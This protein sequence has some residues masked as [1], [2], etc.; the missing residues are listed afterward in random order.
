MPI[1]RFWMI[2]GYDGATRVFQDFRPVGDYSEGSMAQLLKCLTAKASL[3]YAEVLDAYARKNSRRH[4]AH[5]DL[6][7]SGNPFTLMCGS[8][9][10]FT[11]TLV[12]QEKREEVLRREF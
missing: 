9:P 6:L 2:R 8:N 5:L 10:Y 4:A 7:R 1:K 3:E 11:A 12:D